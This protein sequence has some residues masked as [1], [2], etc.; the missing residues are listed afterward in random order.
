[1][2]IKDVMSYPAV[3]CPVD[4]SLDHPA[5]LMWEFDCGVIPVIDAEGRLVGMIT[6]RDICMA[7]LTQGRPLS[8]LPVAPTMGTPAVACRAEDTVESAERLLREVQVHRLPVVDGDGRPVGVISMNDLARLAARA[9]KS[10]VE[11][12]YVQTAAAVGQPRAHAIR[13]APAPIGTS[14]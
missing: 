12:E 4:V 8:D 1:M 11:H 6:D 7:A 2:R 13:L 14:M 3:T 9:K 5:R 10:A